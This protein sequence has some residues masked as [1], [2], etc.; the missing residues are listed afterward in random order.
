[1]LVAFRDQDPNGNGKKDEIPL[2]GRITGAGSSSP[3]DP[4]NYLLNAFFYYNS[5][6]YFTAKNHVLDAPFKSQEYRDALIFI[7]KLYKEGLISQLTWTQSA[8]EERSLLNPDGSDPYLVGVVTASSSSDFLEGKDSIR[9]YSPLKPLKDYTGKGGFSPLNYTRNLTTYISADCAHPVE[10]FK[11]L[12]FMCSQESYLR[13][14]WGEEGVDWVYAEPGKTGNRGGEAKIKVLNPNVFT[15]QNAQ[16][17]H[18]VA[19]VADEKYWQYE[20]DLSDPNA[21]NTM[22]VHKLNE[23]YD[24]AV[25]APQP[26]EI[27]DFAIYSLSDYEER[28]E[29]ARELTDYIVARRS[30]FCTGETDPNNDADWN[31]YLN[32]L[33]ALKYDRWIELAQIGYNRLFE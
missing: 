7:N 13:Q 31:E 3:V 21:W 1:M 12:D 27:F 5:F 24:N 10:A 33:D 17:W 15:D 32:G 19:S 23:V 29:F 30:A 6:T 25:N 26:E 16:C 18:L 22:Y 8:A 2:T 20:V 4:M 9:A 28:S 14:R 11:L